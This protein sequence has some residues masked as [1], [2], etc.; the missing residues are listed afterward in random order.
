MLNTTSVCSLFTNIFGDSQ[1]LQR[2]L[3][4]HTGKTP[5]AASSVISIANTF[6]ISYWGETINLLKMYKI[7]LWIL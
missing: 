7:V 2:H 1:H 6:E 5:A 3:R 4:L